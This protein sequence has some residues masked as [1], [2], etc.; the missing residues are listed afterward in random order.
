MIDYAA[1][2]GEHK[3]RPTVVLLAAIYFA[4]VLTDNL[5]QKYKNVY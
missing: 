1:N 2:N 5:F 4:E 3:H